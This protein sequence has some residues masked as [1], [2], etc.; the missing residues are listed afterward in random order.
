MTPVERMRLDDGAAHLH[1]L[2]AR[3]VAELLVAL[4][5]R[6]GGG[7]ALVELLDEYRRIS[8]AMVRTAGGD[9]VPPRKPRSVPA[10]AMRGA[11]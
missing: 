5:A 9:R 1:A 8:P 10:D 7:A 11:A 2:G 6:V 3:A 4:T